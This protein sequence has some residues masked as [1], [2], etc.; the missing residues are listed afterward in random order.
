MVKKTTKK[1]KTFKIR[2]CPKCGSDEVKVVIGEVGVWECTKCKY[3]GKKI[4]E[5]ELN[6]EQFMEYLDSKGEEVA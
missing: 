1:E 6:E 3:K 5:V 2:K 4:D